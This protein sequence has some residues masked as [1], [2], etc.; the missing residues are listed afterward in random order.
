[1][2]TFLIYG[3]NKLSRYL[4]ET[5]ELRGCATFDITSSQYTENQ[6]DVSAI[7]DTSNTHHLSDSTNVKDLIDTA[8]RLDAPYLFIYKE[9]ED[10]H[11]ESPLALAIDFIKE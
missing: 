9:V 2:Q 7:I 8:K 4:H 10:P 11:P 6:A 1:M 5:L 3:N